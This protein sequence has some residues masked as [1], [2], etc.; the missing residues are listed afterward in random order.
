MSSGAAG[1]VLPRAAADILP[2]L[3][4][5]ADRVGVNFEA[6]VQTARLES[7]FDPAA[8][9]RTSSAAGLFQ[10]IDS[11]WL[12]V[13]GRHGPR[14]GIHAPTRA[15]AL[16]L[17][18]DPRISALMG[19]EHMAENRTRLESGLGR[20]VDSLDIYL[21]HF[22][23]AGGAI[24]FLK[25]LAAE[26]DRAA[27]ELLPA[28]A[29]ANRPIF[30]AASGAARSLAQVHAL[31]ARRF[32]APGAGAA[33]PPAP[34]HRT[35]FPASASPAEADPATADQAAGHPPPAAARAAAQAA[36]M[37]LARLGG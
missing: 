7:G 15:A 28:A 10:F 18:N 20:A 17:R 6:L 12:E 36:Y 31:L 34:A 8:R 22:L 33:P 24:A 19:A 16:A 13:L 3:A 29:R 37:L 25:S 35:A 4:Q 11:T 21:A 2:W 1:R 14:H 5:A 30:Y 9:A 27:N 32:D 23:G 26:P